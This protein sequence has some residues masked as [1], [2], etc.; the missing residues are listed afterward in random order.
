MSVLLTVT[1]IPYL[2]YGVTA[3]PWMYTFHCISCTCPSFGHVTVA[4]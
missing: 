3:Y 2:S 4:G 1:T